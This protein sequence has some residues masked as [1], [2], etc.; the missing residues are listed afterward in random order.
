MTQP[1][2]TPSP[3]I[4]QETWD[5]YGTNMERYMQSQEHKD[6][7]GPVEFHGTPRLG[8]LSKCLRYICA[9]DKELQYDSGS[10]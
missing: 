3:Y 6:A 5:W 2:P 4:D 9:S 10:R 8:Q 1:N 7:G